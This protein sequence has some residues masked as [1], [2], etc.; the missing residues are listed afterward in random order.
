MPPR[1]DTNSLFITERLNEYGIEVRAKAIVGDRPRR[2][3]S[4]PARGAGAHRPGGAVRRTRPDR[5][6]LDARGGVGG[7]RARAARSTPDLLEG[8]RR[9]FAARGARMPEI[10]RR[11]AMVP[12]GAA[13]LPNAFRH[14]ARAVDR[15]RRTRAAPAAGPAGR[16]EADARARRRRAP[17][18]DGRGAAACSGACCA[19]AGA[20]SRKST[21]WRAPVYSRWAAE[22]PPVATTVLTRRRRSNCTCR[23]AGRRPPMPA[24]AARRRRCR[25]GGAVRRGRLQHRRPRHR[26]GGRRAAARPPAGASP[27]PSRAPGDSSRS[28]LTDVPGSSDYVAVQRGLL[29]QRRRR[30][31]CSAC[32]R[33]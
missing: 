10:N 24:R 12:E 33:P 18:A 31:R 7:H 29:Q 15:A 22:A 8:I 20:P 23:C 13:V 32:R 5:R 19:S 28:R 14:G 3:R 25:T 11:Q 6:R 30:R 2:S 16:A 1:L 4:R 21:S 9:R 26:G 27:S 17:R